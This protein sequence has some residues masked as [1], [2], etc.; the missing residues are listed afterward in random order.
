MQAALGKPTLSTAVRRPSLKAAEFQKA[1]GT[2]PVARTAHFV[3]H[4][5]PHS[6]APSS[7]TTALIVVGESELS[8]APATEDMACVDELLPTTLRTAPMGPLMGRLGVVFPKRLARRSVTRSLLRHQAREA[9][10]RH[11]S[12]A[13]QAGWGPAHPGDAWV[14]RLRAPF[15]KQQFPSAASSALNRVV[16]LELDALWAALCAKAPPLSLHGTAG[17]SA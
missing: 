6:A 8:T 14:V 12:A 4:H 7:Q 3:L 13:A 11:A 2:R 9:V 10:L 1:L 15:D 17:R 16:R 5:L